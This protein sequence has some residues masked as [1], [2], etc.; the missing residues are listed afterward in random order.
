[1]KNTLKNYRN[2]TS[3]HAINSKSLALLHAKNS[4]RWLVHYHIATK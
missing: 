4:A 1:M 2:H 3:K